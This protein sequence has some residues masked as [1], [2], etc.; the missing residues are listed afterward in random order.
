M[1]TVR[2]AQIEAIAEAAEEGL[3]L[4]CR[5]HLESTQAE[6]CAPLL[7]KGEKRLALRVRLG[8]QRARR[9]GFKS[10]EDL[11]LFLELMCEF[12]RDFDRS[13]DVPWAYAV[14]RSPLPARQKILALA[15]RATA[16]RVERI[17]GRPG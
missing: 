17:T 6:A 8:L 7:A 15:E 11:R 5:R 4:R 9:H 2:N 16:A 12:G 14:F 1:L 13:P 3:R 10:E